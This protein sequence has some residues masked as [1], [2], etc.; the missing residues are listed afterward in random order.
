MRWLAHIPLRV[1]LLL[2]VL[3]LGTFGIVRAQSEPVP[4]TPSYF[5]GTLF[6][7]GSPAA[8]GTVVCGRIGGVDKGC[9]TTTVSGQYGGAGGAEL[10]LSVQGSATEIDALIAFFVT[11]PGTVG[12]LAAE[13]NVFDPGEGGVQDLTLATTPAAVPTPPSWW[14]PWHSP[15]CPTSSFPPPRSPPRVR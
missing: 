5:H 6:I 15:C 1:A 12:G 3:A 14:R 8:V 4:P 2:G 7:A 10:K 13:T 9:I 11:P